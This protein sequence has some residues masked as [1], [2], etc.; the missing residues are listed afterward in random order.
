MTSSERQIKR[1]KKGPTVEVDY[2]KLMTAMLP[3]FSEVMAK[4]LPNKDQYDKAIAELNNGNMHLQDLNKK[5]VGEFSTSL[6]DIENRL[7]KIED[8]LGIAKSEIV[9][10]LEALAA[11][12]PIVAECPQVCRFGSPDC[13]GVPPDC[14]P[15]CVAVATQTPEE[16]TPQENP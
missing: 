9:K 13:S 6:S 2:Q 5:L 1:R 15:A 8:K 4:N 16:K 11:D 3:Q 10:E 12:D 7:G 14:C